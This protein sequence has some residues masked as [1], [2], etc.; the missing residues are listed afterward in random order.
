MNRTNFVAASLLGAVAAAGPGIPA[1]L[2][3]TEAFVPVTQAMQ[4]NPDPADWLHISRTYDQHRF[5]PLSQINKDIEASTPAIVSPPLRLEKKSVHRA[6]LPEPVV[7]T[8]R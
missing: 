4:A 3:Q 5:S 2:A 1:V 7:P 8:L 6:G